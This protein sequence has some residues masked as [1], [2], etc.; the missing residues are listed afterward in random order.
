MI[1]CHYT[2][3][4]PTAQSSVYLPIPGQCTCDF[5]LLQHNYDSLLFKY[6]TYCY[7]NILYCF[8]PCLLLFQY[9]LFCYSNVQSS[10]LFNLASRVIQEIQ[11]RLNIFLAFRTSSISQS[12][13]KF[14]SVEK[15]NHIIQLLLNHH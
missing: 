4:A 2:L 15:P 13:L 3:T 1:I 8:F 5:S 14:M 7:V 6:F 10:V 11:Y 9:N 12:M